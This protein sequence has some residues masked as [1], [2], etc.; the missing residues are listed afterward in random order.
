MEGQAP[1]TKDIGVIPPPSDI[2]TGVRADISSEFSSPILAT[3]L[4]L[5]DTES[6]RITAEDA[7]KSQAEKEAANSALIDTMVE[8]FDTQGQYG[9]VVGEKEI[10]TGSGGT[11]D[12]RVLI[13]NYLREDEGSH[14]AEVTMI[15]RDGIKKLEVDRD[16]TGIKGSRRYKIIKNLTSGEKRTTSGGGDGFKFRARGTEIGLRY[17]TPEG[18]FIEQLTVSD[19]GDVLPFE[20]TSED[21]QEIV[22]K[23][24][25]QTE[26]PHKAIVE[27]NTAEAQLANSAAEMI[28]G[29]PPRP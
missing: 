6:K 10:K 15:T 2:D 1:G 21:F 28:R 29:L 11:E 16:S 9:V 3:D 24:I 22:K 26:S 13:L 27:K 4:H 17:S 20:G 14:T 12:R 25:D 5:P 23:S 8:S 18:N 7:E 19:S